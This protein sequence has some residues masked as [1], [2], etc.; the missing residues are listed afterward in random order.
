M[1]IAIID[2]GINQGL[3]DNLKVDNDIEI[4]PDLK[5]K[6]RNNDKL[7]LSIHGTTCA[8]I[9]KKYSSQ[10]IF[11]SIKIL[12]KKSQRGKNTQLIKALKW[13][14]ANE[15]RLIHLSI[16][17]IDYRDFDDLK[18][19]IN[20]ITSEGTIIIAATNNDYSFT[21]PASSTNVIGVSCNKNYIDNQYSFY[22]Y[23]F[24]GINV[25]ASG[26]HLLTTVDG[27]ENYTLPSNSFAAPLVSAMVSNILKKYGNLSLEE[28][29]EKLYLKSLND[30]NRMLYNPYIKINTD[31]IKGIYIISDPD[32][33]LDSAYLYNKIIQDVLNVDMKQNKFSK[34]VKII[35]SYLLNR[36]KELSDCD[37]FVFY[38]PQNP[39]VNLII[40]EIKYILEKYSINLVLINNK[41]NKDLVK[42]I[43]SRIWLPEYYINSLYLSK[44]KELDIPLIGIYNFGENSIFQYLL[45]KLNQLF[46]DEGYYSVAMSS[47]YDAILAG[48]EYMPSNINLKKYFSS[49]YNKYRCDL[50]ISGFDQ[51]I[52]KEKC[53][54]CIRSE[55]IDVM[56]F[57]NKNGKKTINIFCEEK[58]INSSF[59]QN[60][61]KENIHII[62]NQI[63]RLFN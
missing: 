18:K 17:T 45:I 21:Y 6:P 32:I 44:G 30:K 8:A 11:N 40:K 46:R 41:I 63:L 16:G 42:K 52:L 14:K 51:N 37:A 36:L 4:L 19:C 62:Y 25:S 58:N 1:E 23:P 60:K 34:N 61:I 55:H 3:Y 15:I 57:I 39:M 7:G 20:D 13:C 53:E 22:Y 24:N 38:M 35:E 50:L 59:S 31:W 26:K 43:K 33:F 12:N 9:I 5:I 49:I 2:D 28:V 48:M 56:L 29:K 47:S 54:W 27:K 10:I